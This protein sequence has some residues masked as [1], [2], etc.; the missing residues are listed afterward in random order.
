VTAV[1]AHWVG[2]RLYAEMTVAV[3]AGLSLA[4]GQAI[5]EAIRHAAQHAVPHLGELTIQL[6]AAETVA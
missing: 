2:H 4:G 5:T 6:D 3:D 1:R